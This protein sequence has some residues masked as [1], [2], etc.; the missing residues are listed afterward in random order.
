MRGGSIVGGC[1]GFT[2]VDWRKNQPA[3]E[4]LT[5]SQRK[6]TCRALIH[7]ELRK[8]KT[9][10]DDEIQGGLATATKAQGR[11]TGR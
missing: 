8:P 6:V 1:R 2:E 4:N 11:C 3:D 7:I 9:N 10:V 5:I